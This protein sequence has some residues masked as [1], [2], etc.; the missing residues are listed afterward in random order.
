[1]QVQA[2]K[3]NCLVAVAKSVICVNADVLG[4]M[5]F[6]DCVCWNNRDRIIHMSAKIYF[7][8]HRNKVI[9]IFVVFVRD[10][11]GIIDGESMLIHAD[12]YTTDFLLKSSPTSFSLENII[13]SALVNRFSNAVLK[14]KFSMFRTRFRLSKDNLVPAVWHKLANN[15][16]RSLFLWL[17]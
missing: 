4:T 11:W 5:C 2:R 12:C 6:N 14:I 16:K 8:S 1:M 10:C 17:R 9:V 15:G 13:P 7:F 3:V